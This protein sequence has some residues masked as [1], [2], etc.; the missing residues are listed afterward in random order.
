MI[1]PITE[2]PRNIALYGYKGTGKTTLAGA[3]CFYNKLWKQ[4]SFAGPLKEMVRSFLLS[5]GLSEME[6]G[7]YINEGKD[8]VIPQLGVSVRELLSRLTGFYNWTTAL[9]NKITTLNGNFKNV[10]IDDLRLPEEYD[11]LREHDFFL[12]RMYRPEIGLDIY[13]DFEGKLDDREFD[14]TFDFSDMKTWEFMELMRGV[15]S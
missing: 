9:E 2:L 14:L 6:A 11:M 15:M 1:D 13:D 4:L 12:V 8:T 5:S 3:F 10:I 7:L